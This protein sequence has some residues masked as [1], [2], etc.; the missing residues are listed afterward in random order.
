[1]ILR[2]PRSTRTDTLFPYTTLFRSTGRGKQLTDV[3]Q[4][5]IK[6]A[7]DTETALLAIR[8]DVL[9]DQLDNIRWLALG[10]LIL[11]FLFCALALAVVQRTLATPMRHLT[12]LVAR[13]TGGD[14]RIE[15]P[16][17]ERGD[18][19]GAIARAIE[20]FR[21]ASQEVQKREWLKRHHAQ[22]SGS[23]QG[24]GR[25]GPKVSDWGG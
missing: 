18:E 16:H 2:L 1:M 23:G 3:I 14:L 12:D 21:H 9:S 24:R 17:T 15:V 7:A 25:V 5:Q 22:Q 20:D 8:N 10:S 13:L 6:Q 11:G 4:A 19:V